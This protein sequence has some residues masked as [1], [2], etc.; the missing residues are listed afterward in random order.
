MTDKEI[1]EK[2]QDYMRR[3]NLRQWELARKI[4]V[5]ERTLSRWL[6]GTTKVSRA[7]LRILKNEKI[8]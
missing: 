1:A 6:S 8:I 2:L 4:E 3:N 7:Y 5:P